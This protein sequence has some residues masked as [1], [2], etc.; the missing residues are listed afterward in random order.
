MMTCWCWLGAQ[1]AAAL[2]SNVRES[3]KHVEGCLVAVGAAE[4]VVRACVRSTCGS[5]CRYDCVAD[6]VIVSNIEQKHYCAALAPSGMYY[7]QV[8][9]CFTLS[10]VIACVLFCAWSTRF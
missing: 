10:P 3:V 4:W 2:R 6:D 9:Q 8:Q 1:A 7:H 5:A